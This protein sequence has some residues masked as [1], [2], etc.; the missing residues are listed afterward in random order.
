MKN[1]PVLIVLLLLNAVVLLGQLWPSGAPPFARYVN[2]AFLVSSL[3]YF[4]WALRYN[5]D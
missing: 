1:R 2:I 4:V 5:C 3:L